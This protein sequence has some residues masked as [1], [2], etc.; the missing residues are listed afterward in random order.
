LCWGRREEGS[1]VNRDNNYKSEEGKKKNQI[2][3]GPPPLFFHPALFKRG[4]ES[5][6]SALKNKI[7]E[8]SKNVCT[9]AQRCR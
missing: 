4:R 5:L 7:R 9:R 1:A 6:C 2:T 8:L 3:G